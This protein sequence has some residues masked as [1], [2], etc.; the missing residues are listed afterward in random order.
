MIKTNRCIKVVLYINIIFIFLMLF[1]EKASAETLPKI[2]LQSY[3]IEEGNFSM[4]EVTKLKL[5]FMMLKFTIKTLG[6]IEK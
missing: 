5:E 4:G 2:V 6:P 1:S 3:S